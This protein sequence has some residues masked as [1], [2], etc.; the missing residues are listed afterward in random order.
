L[1]RQ[2][3]AKAV[4]EQP[5]NPQT[6]LALARYDLNRNPRAAL[7][8]LRAAIYLNPESI[9]PELLTPERADR[10]AIEIYNDYIQALRA[11][12]AQAAAV[13]GG[14]Q[15]QLALGAQHPAHLGEPPDRVGDV[16]DHLAGPHHVELGVGQRPGALQ[17]E[18][19]CVQA[20]HRRARPAQR[21][22]GHVG[23]D[24]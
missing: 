24:H 5:S 22:L 17:G 2:T 8:E 9:A 19:A 16:L 11:T 15:Q 13:P 3:L 20:R 10:E 14:R 18:Q 12:Q 23:S 21:L 4:R 6:W 7:N 1:A